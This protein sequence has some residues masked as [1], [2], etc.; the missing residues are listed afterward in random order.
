MNHHCSKCDKTTECS[1]HTPT[2][3]GQLI[4]AKCTVCGYCNPE[5]RPPELTPQEREK[6]EKG[7]INHYKKKMPDEEFD[8]IADECLDDYHAVF[9]RLAEI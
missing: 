2:H 3:G 1:P 4:Y 5:Y 9:E 7:I 6:F 8:R